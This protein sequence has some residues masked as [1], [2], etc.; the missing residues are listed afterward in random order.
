MA[1]ESH[2]A[3]MQQDFGLRYMRQSK[4]WPFSANNQNTSRLVTVTTDCVE[5]RIR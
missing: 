4:I 3:Q 5:R 1:I 2:E